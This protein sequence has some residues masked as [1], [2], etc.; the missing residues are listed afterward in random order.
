MAYAS[1]PVIGVIKERPPVPVPQDLPLPTLEL[2]SAEEFMESDSDSDPIEA[3]QYAH[4][5]EVVL[6]GFSSFLAISGV[7]LIWLMQRRD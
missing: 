2:E 7:L 5:K 3:E 1:A 6:P 4:I